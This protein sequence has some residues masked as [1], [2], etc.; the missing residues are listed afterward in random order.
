[1][2]T[3]L[4]YASLARSHCCRRYFRRT[5]QALISELVETLQKP[6]ESDCKLRMLRAAHHKDLLS[7]LPTLELSEL[8]QGLCETALRNRAPDDSNEVKSL[9]SSATFEVAS[10]WAQRPVLRET[11]RARALLDQVEWRLANRRTVSEQRFHSLKQYVL[12]ALTGLVFAGFLISTKLPWLLT[13]LPPLALAGAFVSPRSFGALFTAALF[14][15]GGNLIILTQRAE[16]CV[17]LPLLFASST[18]LVRGQSELHRLLIP[19]SYYFAGAL[20][21]LISLLLF[22]LSPFPGF[23]SVNVVVFLV[24]SGLQAP[25]ALHWLVDICHH[26][27]TRS[28]QR[29]MMRKE[30]QACILPIFK[31]VNHFW[32]PPPAWTLALAEFRLGK[33]LN[34]DPGRSIIADHG[35]ATLTLLG[36]AGAASAFLFVCACKAEERH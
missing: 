26:L 31:Q 28:F 16:L 9:L 24:S 3:A 23:A 7:F 12:V 2:C 35:L 29:I 14:G 8:L 19:G 22:P 21:R 18:A 10:S 5:G 27:L 13:V 20:L 15:I 6:G 30:V 17:L 4:L 36:L 25:I 33:G 1:M 32:R 34:W 11:H